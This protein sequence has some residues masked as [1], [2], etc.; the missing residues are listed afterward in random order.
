MKQRVYKYLIP[1]LLLMPMLMGCNKM[2]EIVFDHELPKFDLREDA[3][4]IELIVPQGTQPDDQLYIVGQFNGGPEAA[5]GSSKWQ[6]EKASDTNDKWGIYLFPSDFISGKSLS[7][8]FYFVSDQHGVE[9]TLKN[10]EV[11]H[12]L[13]ASVGN[14]YNV[15]S[16]RWESYFKT[17]EEPEVIEH[18]GFVIYVI[19]NTGWQSTAL[20]AWGSDLPEL[21]GGWPGITATGTDKK[22]GKVYHY[23]DTG[24]ENKGLT[25]TLIFNPNGGD[26]KQLPDFPVTL[27]KDYYLELT[28]EGVV[29][30]GASEP[31][32]E[33]DGFAIFIENKTGWDTMALYAWAEG[34][35]ELFG[36]W[37]GIVSPTG[38]QTI[39]GVTY[40]YY[41]TGSSNEGKTYNL[42]LNDTTGKQYEMA[43]VTL[44]KHHYFRASSDAAEVVDDTDVDNDTTEDS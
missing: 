35:A 36:G 18:D 41:D 30:L 5:L 1:L 38:Q 40:D 32:I 42:I 34:E 7:D 20:Y 37:P 14:R 24:S 11:L 10:E 2:E 33:H 16:Y 44:D 22:D 13:E 31:E 39:D 29:D 17:P 25:Y 12:E 15:T 6:L 26:G 3:I 23:Y 43:T 27:T 21:F 8:G 4:L 19:D 9:R 28:P